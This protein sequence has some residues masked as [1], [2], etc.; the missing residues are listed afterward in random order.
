MLKA[1]Q[2]I[3][4]KDILKLHVAKEANLCGFSFHVPCNEIRQY[5]CYGKMF[6]VKVNN[7]ETTNGFYV[8]I[9]RVREGGDFSGLDTSTYDSSKE[10]GNTPFS[11]AMI[12]PLILHVVAEDP[13]VMNKTLQSFLNPYGKK[14][15]LA[16]AIIQ[17]SRTQAWLKLFG[18][19][20]INVKY[21]KAIRNEIQGKGHI[22]RMKFMTRRET[23]N[24]IKRTV[25]LEE[26]QHRRKH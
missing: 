15:A 22:V 6:V 23:L 7:N 2:T 10:K 24:N 17:D 9:C 12:V 3:P 16:D 8:S 13:F 19:P 20:E 21:A 5:K 1:G 18:M 14:F 26:L 25:I 11:T 4:D